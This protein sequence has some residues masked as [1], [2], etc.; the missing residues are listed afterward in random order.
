MRIVLQRVRKASVTVEG[1]EDGAGREVASIGPGLVALVGFSAKEADVEAQL[2][3]LAKKLVQ[4]RIFDDGSG[5]MN[6][7]VA[8]I[9]GEILLIPEVTLTT[10]LQKGTR[11]SFHT[12]AKPETA[13]SLF[14][15]FTQAV[16]ATYPRVHYGPFQVH[17]VISLEN[18]GPVTFV[19]DQA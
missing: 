16:R 10:T 5:R 9:D 4:M 13:R 14:D 18:D 11:P 19:L 7:S 6:R 1:P 17:M 15:R 8:D 12:A 2:P 3:R